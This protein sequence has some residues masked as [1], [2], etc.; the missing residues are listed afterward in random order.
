MR[1]V[2]VV[3][4]KSKKRFPIFGWLIRLWTWKPY[5]HVALEVDM[6]WAGG[7]MYFQASEGKVN[8]EFETHFFKENEIVKKYEIQ[9]PEDVY[10][11]L[12]KERI[13]TA[14]ENYGF[15][16]NLGIAY[17]DVARIFGFNPKNPWKKGK[18][19][20]ELIY[21]SVLKPLYPYLDFDS[22]LIKPHHIEKIIKNIENN[23]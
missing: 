11:D 21:K 4:T 16:Q 15:L 9:V 23:T 8:Y 10:K 7:K 22:Q 14:G 18:N 2:S 20:S 13:R 12:A 19:C 1:I 17:V 3:F 5:S 6:G